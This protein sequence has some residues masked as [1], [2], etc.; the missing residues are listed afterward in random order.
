[1]VT[2]IYLDYDMLEIMAKADMRL[3]MLFFELV[4]VNVQNVIFF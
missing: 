4:V 1:L 3:F 2:H